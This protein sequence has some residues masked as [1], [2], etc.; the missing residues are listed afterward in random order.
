MK[1]WLLT[2]ATIGLFASAVSYTV[3]VE[4]DTVAHFPIRVAAI[5]VW[6]TAMLLL[7]N[8]GTT[9]RVEIATNFAK[10]IGGNIILYA[11]VGALL[12]WVRSVVRKAMSRDPE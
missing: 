5:L 9:D 11:A 12:F 8:E 10:A 7:A 1:R 4:T 2:S 3:L 6:P